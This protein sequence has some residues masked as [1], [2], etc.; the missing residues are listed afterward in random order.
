MR[1]QTSRARSLVIAALVA[2]VVALVALQLGQLRCGAPRV[3]VQLDAGAPAPPPTKALAAPGSMPAPTAGPVAALLESLRLTGHVVD[4]TGARVPGAGVL[5]SGPVVREAK[6]NGN[7][8]FVFDGLHPN[9]YEVEAWAGDA[10]GGPLRVHLTRAT[11]PVAI[12]LFTAARL[13]VTVVAA[14]GGPIADANV[15]LRAA[16]MQRNLTIVRRGKTDA[17]GKLVLR[18]VIPGGYDIAAWATGYRHRGASLE[19]PAGLKW[20]I[21]LEL[22]PGAPVSGRVVDEKGL[23]VVGADVIASPAMPARGTIPRRPPTWP[24]NPKTDAN[25]YF[26][27]EALSAGQYQFLANHPEFDLGWSSIY[28]VD[29]VSPK[30]GIIIPLRRGR[31]ISG[32]VVNAAGEPMP[33]ATVRTSTGY[34]GALMAAVVEG[35]CDAGGRF[36]LGG[37]SYGVV[38]VLAAHD[39]ILSEPLQVDLTDRDRADLVLPLTM[40]GAV[41]GVVLNPDRTPVAGAIVMC[42]SATRAAVGLRPVLPETTDVQGRFACRGLPP[43][44]VHVSATRPGANYNIHP[45]LRADAKNA[46]VGDENLEIVIPDDGSL[47]GRVRLAGGGPAKE[48]TLSLVNGLKPHLFRTEDGAFTLDELAAMTYE[49]KIV[50]PKHKTKKLM[51]VVRQKL[52]NDLGEIVLEEG[53]DPPEAQRPPPLFPAGGKALP[54]GQPASAPT[55]PGGPTG[56]ARGRRPGGA[57]GEQPGGPAGGPPAAEGSR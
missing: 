20:E 22:T 29:G 48:Y 5:L 37:L 46:K 45:G 33:F 42:V 40:D 21:K 28:D 55:G 39:G 54:I 19:P 26:T 12:R 50:A 1:R 41:A 8:E 11:P 38:H 57:P 4:G 35:T 51:V 10:A 3:V 36:R 6:A 47:S 34:G 32:W 16:G 44:G 9:S 53:A 23:P 43:G 49:M 14:G 15:E 24:F 13:E 27:Y 17:Q 52:K 7:G 18:G 2:V 31:T 30:S 25:G 56:D